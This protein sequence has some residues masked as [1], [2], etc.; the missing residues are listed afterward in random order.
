VDLDRPAE[1]NM[2]AITMQAFFQRCGQDLSTATSRARVMSGPKTLAVLGTTGFMGPHIVE[3]LL[4]ARPVS[5]IFC[6]N[7]SADAQR[8]TKSAFREL[9]DN[10]S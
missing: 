4:E 9:V 1:V 8:R 7:R 5:D 6:F 2:N 3:P 10:L